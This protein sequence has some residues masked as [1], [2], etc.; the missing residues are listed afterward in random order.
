M[1]SV[2]ELKSKNARAVHEKHLDLVS[3]YTTH[4]AAVEALHKLARTQI[5]DDVAAQLQLSDEGRARVLLYLSDAANLFRFY[6]RARYDEQAALA[7]LNATVLWRMRTDLDLLS[8]ASLNP[9]Y[10]TPP[11]PNP[12]LFWVNS[13]FK[14][15][16]GRPCGVINLRSVERT[17]ENTLD[18]LKEYIVACMEIM[19][20][21]VADPTPQQPAHEE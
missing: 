8:L 13:G 5:V 12:P 17:A 14:D 19:R 21:Y 11:P 9:L 20:R 10:V 16:Y 1:P 2:Q 4:A 7:L 18:Q 6:R 15:F 3:K